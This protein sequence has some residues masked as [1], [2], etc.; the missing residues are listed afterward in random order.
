M[1]PRAPRPCAFALLPAL[2][3]GGCGSESL[4]SHPVTTGATIELPPMTEPDAGTPVPPAPPGLG[5]TVTPAGVV[6]RVW[7]PHATA[8]QVVGDFAEQTAAML[9]SDDGV[10]TATVAGAHAG[11]V[12]HYAFD[13]SAGAITRI[14]PRCRQIVPDASGCVVVDPAAYAWKSGAFARPARDA[15]VVYE[16]HVGSFAVSAGAPGGTFADAR[17]R[18]ADLADLGVSVVELMPVQ[19]F[20]G[21]PNGWGYNPQLYFAPKPT[22]GGADELRAFVDEAHA[23]GIAVWLDTVVNH[24]DGWSKA[25]LRCFDGDCGGAAGIYFFPPGDYATT[26]WGPRPDYTAPQP[27]AMLL[28]TV[29]WW[30]G[31][32]RGDGFRW[33]SVSNIRALD[34][35]GE[36]PGGKALCLALNAATHDA[37]ALSVAE[38]LK[39]YDAITR[40]AD[41]G[42]FAFDAQWDG[43]GYQVNGVIVP[44]ADDGRDLGAIQAA[45]LGGYAGDPFARLLFTEDHD[46]VGNGGARLPSAVDPAN[47]V[48]FA[49]RRRSM[50]AAAL[51]LTAPGVPMLFMGQESLATGTFKNPPDPLVDALPPE[52]TKVRAY[53]KDLIALRRNLGGKSG[54][55]REPGVEILHRNDTNK[56]LAYRRHGASGEDV[57]VVVNL[58]NKA[59]KQYDIGVP[60]AGTWRIRLDADWAAY[61]DDFTGGQTGSVDTLAMVKDGQPNTLPVKLGAYAAVVL[62]R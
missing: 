30:L 48:S 18:L 33:D 45:L 53:Y 20:G 38:D 14:D 61:G 59:Y 31:E 6:F 3:L 27:T 55:L 57:V 60:G 24:A 22:Y 52:G 34:G 46:T 56:V 19:D 5:A 16:M 36:T 21:K 7:A 9:P 23:Q 12:Y 15:A 17:A 49:A 37:G 29:P 51:L 28:D 32:N 43:F 2:A 8:A 35:K 4:G 40:P 47:P 39:G 50:L 1:R 10:L 62:T 58:R 25:P 44:F 42:G 11:T 54:G 26:P 13:T 41:Q